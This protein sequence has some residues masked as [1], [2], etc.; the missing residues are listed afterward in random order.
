MPRI[1]SG[2]APKY[3]KHKASGQ[4]IVTLCGRDFY[5]GLHGSTSSRREYDRLILEWEAHGRRLPVSDPECTV[6]ELMAAYLRHAKIYYHG[7]SEYDATL[8]SVR[9][10][11]ELYGR[12]LV[13]EF[14]P[15]KLKVV[16]QKMIDADLCRNEI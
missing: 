1:T 2:A 4:A 7:S 3:R 12:L 11:K 6:V 15:L 10:L 14:G 16:R 9:P 13:E 8:T 5:L